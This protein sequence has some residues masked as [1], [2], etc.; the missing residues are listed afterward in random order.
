MDK[1]LPFVSVICLC[2]N[3]EPFIAETLNSV[4]A[5]SYPNIEILIIDDASTDKSKIIIQEFAKKN[6]S[7]KTNYLSKNQGNCKA[8]NIA[9][10]QAKGK[11]VIDLACDDLLLSTRIEK[12]VSVFENST[13][14]IAMVFSNTAIIDGK[15][16]FLKNYYKINSDGKS[17]NQ[18]PVGDV[19]ENIVRES[20]ISTPSMMFRKSVLDELGG[21][22]ETLKYEDF[23]IW[24]RMARNYH[25]L[26][27]DEVLTKK[28]Q[29]GGSLGSQFYQIGNP[30]VESSL[31]VCQKILSM[32]KTESENKA[33]AKRVR[34]FMRQSLYTHQFGLAKNFGELL[35]QADKIDFISKLVLFL[36]KIHFPANGFYRIYVWLID[37]KMFK[38]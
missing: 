5:Q 29:V 15:G 24:I 6:P 9:L 16:N 34:F 30:L 2:Y 19:Y 11:Y 17:I 38:K 37:L 8:F 31:K 13:E 27:V 7:V 26:Y 18:I 14:K 25:F 22:D 12:Q 23:D 28:R 10:K 35:K 21:Y 1:N 3:H 33:L 4:L 32:N 20:Y 36:A